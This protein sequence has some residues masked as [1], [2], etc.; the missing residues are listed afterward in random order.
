MESVQSATKNIWDRIKAWVEENPRRA[1]IWAGGIVLFL[2]SFVIR[3][4]APHVSLAGEALFSAG[5]RW[6]TN[7]LVTTVVVD[8]I[9]IVLALLATMRMQ[10]VP[11]TWQNMIEMTIEW[12]YGLAEGVAASQA[13]K[14]FPWVATVFFFVIVSNW[15]GLFPGVG[16]IG[17]YHD[18]E[19]AEEH[20]IV[21]SEKLAMVNGTLIWTQPQDQATDQPVGLAA[22]EAEGHRKFVPLFR[23]PSADLNT[24]FALALVIMTMVQVFGVQA[25]GGGYF[26]KFINFR[27]EGFMKWMNGIVGILEII[28]EISRIIAFGFRLFGNIFAGE[29]ILATMAFLITF[30]LPIPFYILELFVGFVQALVFAMLALV[31]FSMATISH[32]HD[33]SHGHAAH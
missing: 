12:L 31:F 14:F 29:I 23:P 5:P 4:E 22:A 17:Y 13:R 9:V 25:L 21:L 28:S 27:G 8:L 26:S 11:P 33:D 19:A 7:S 20:A 15:F 10:I 6:L 30:L 16:S 2:L 3:A 24:T 1:A 32:G 18:G